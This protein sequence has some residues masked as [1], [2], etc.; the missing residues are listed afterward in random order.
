LACVW[1]RGMAFPLRR[2]SSFPF[3]RRRS[4]RQPTYQTVRLTFD[5]RSPWIRG[6]V[7]NISAGGAC[8][9]ISSAKALPEEFTLVFPPNTS[10]RCRLVWRSGDRLGVQFLDNF[11]NV[12]PSSPELHE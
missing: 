11:P 12:D 9:G 4:P 3:E 1:G 2:F 6:I 7:E 8:V 5:D 10:R